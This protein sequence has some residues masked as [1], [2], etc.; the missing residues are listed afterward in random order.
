MTGEAGCVVVLARALSADS[1]SDD[2]EI[3]IREAIG[4]RLGAAACRGVRVRSQPRA[5]AKGHI[6][7]VEVALDDVRLEQLP[8]PGAA[9]EAVGQVHRGRIEELLFDVTS[10]EV[11]GLIAS[12]ARLAARQV[13]YAL[14]VGQ[15]VSRLWLTDIAAG[16]AELHIGRLELVRTIE[17]RV[18][19][20]RKLDLTLH[21]GG[22]VEARGTVRV[23]AF[24]IRGTLSGELGIENGEAIVLRRVDLRA[25]I[26][27]A[28]EAVRE[29]VVRSVNP[30]IDVRTL[31]D[32]PFGIRLTSV[33]TTAEEL[34]VSAVLSAN[35]PST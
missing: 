23:G 7:A 3:A 21:P 18:A 15:S 14:E 30:L 24:G 6:D 26:L 10:L 8:L 2:I 13:D 9:P 1:S 25:G 35:G 33:E 27:G 5:L 31:L 16:E 32:R 17:H 11:A 19:S 20:V 34:T 4:A 29:T 12:R 22:H 28:P